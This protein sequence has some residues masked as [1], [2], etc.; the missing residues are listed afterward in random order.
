MTIEVRKV[1]EDFVLAVPDQL[2][3]QLGWEAGDI[4]KVE[5]HGDELRIV[6]VETA[7]HARAMQFARRAMEKYRDALEKLAKS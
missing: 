4:C 6:R 3:S 7:K 2:A 5:V 1:G